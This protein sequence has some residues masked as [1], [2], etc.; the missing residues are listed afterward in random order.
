MFEG[1][2]TLVLLIVIGAAIMFWMMFT[3]RN[4]TIAPHKS[5]HPQEYYGD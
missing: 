4:P 1:L 3:E 5:Y 2:D